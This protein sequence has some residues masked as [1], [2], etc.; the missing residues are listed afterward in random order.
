MQD[1]GALSPEQFEE[2]TAPLREMQGGRVT[3]KLAD[4][5][6]EDVFRD[7]R[8]LGASDEAAVAPVIGS[9]SA[10]FTTEAVGQERSSDRPV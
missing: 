7:Q 8:S 1:A 6:Y 9:I 10:Y 2:W 4:Q 5:A 3:N